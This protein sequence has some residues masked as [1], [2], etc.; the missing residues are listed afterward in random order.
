VVSSVVIQGFSIILTVVVAGR[1]S[2]GMTVAAETAAD[3]NLSL[4]SEYGSHVCGSIAAASENLTVAAS[5]LTNLHPEEGDDWAAAADYLIEGLNTIAGDPDCAQARI[6]LHRQSPGDTPL[7]F[8]NT[9][10]RLSWPVAEDP[11]G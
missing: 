3:L 5:A 1:F 4:R 8:P 6:R 10:Y 7:Q 11:R 9:I 2:R